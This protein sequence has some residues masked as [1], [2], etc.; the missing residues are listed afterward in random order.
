MKEE[1]TK[2]YIPYDSIILRS[3]KCKLVFSGRRQMDVFPW[4]QGWGTERN[5][6]HEAIRKI[7]GVM[8][9]FMI[10]IVVPVSQVYKYVKTYQ[11]MQFVAC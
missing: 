9:V 2:E 11:V 3:G 10:S 8:G 1:D 7:S 4:A 6:L 5:R